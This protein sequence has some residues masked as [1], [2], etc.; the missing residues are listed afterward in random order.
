MKSIDVQASK[1]MRDMTIQVSVT[2]VRRVV[3]RIRVG[4]AL[5]KAAA[6]VMGCGIEIACD[7]AGERAR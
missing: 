4:A 2:G 7:G 6:W 3:W 5:M 1:L